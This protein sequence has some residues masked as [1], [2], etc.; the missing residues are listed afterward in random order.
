[1]IRI[2]SKSPKKKELRKQKTFINHAKINNSV[3]KE[4]KKKDDIFWDPE[5]DAE[6][7]S[8]IN[9]NFISIEDIYNGKNLDEDK[10]KDKSEQ[11][12]NDDNEQFL[13]HIQAKEINIENERDDS[14]HDRLKRSG[15]E[16]M[17][18]ER[19]NAEN[20]ICNRFKEFISQD[21]QVIENEKKNFL[22]DPNKKEEYKFEEDLREDFKKKINKISEIP[23]E[24]FPSNGAYNGK[25]IETYLR[26]KSSIIKFHEIQIS[27]GPKRSTDD[28]EIKEKDEENG[29]ISS[30]RKDE[31]NEKKYFI[32]EANSD[33]SRSQIKNNKNG[34]I[35][36]FQEDNNEQSNH[37]AFSS[38]QM[39]T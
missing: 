28:S 24:L 20:K 23:V 9:H 33:S 5:I 3:K 19:I 4:E 34:V 38:E 22:I 31:D 13:T 17:E 10:D 27:L 35:F 26:F 1:L 39:H 16:H 11:S 8:Y 15:N 14:D 6:T 21:D 36:N 2:D 18:V 12:Q 25:K 30:S 7:L 32:Y 37:S 29:D